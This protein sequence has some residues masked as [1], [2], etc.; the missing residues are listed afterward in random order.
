MTA[1]EHEGNSCSTCPALIDASDF[2]TQ[3]EV[4][5]RPTNSAT[6]RRF[7]TIIS[8]TKMEGWQAEERARE[9]GSRCDH[10][11]RYCATSSQKVFLNIGVGAP[12]APPEPQK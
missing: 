5:G 2:A 4:Y 6:C 10:H 8:T 7:G 9:V 1:P 12:P 11:G 3:S